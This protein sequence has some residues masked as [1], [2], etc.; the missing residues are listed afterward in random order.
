[1]ATEP[2]GL[3]ALEKV[4]AILAN[5]AIYE[6]ANLIPPPDPK[7]G[8]RPRDYPAWTLIFWEALISV[9]GSARRVE[10]ELS[11][12]LVWQ[13]IR[14]TVKR[15]FPDRPELHLPARPM[16]RHHYLYGRDRYLTDPNVLDALASRHRQLATAQARQF[17]LLDPEGPGSWTHPDLSRMLYADGKV[18]APLFRAK[19]GDTHVNRTT[20]EITLRRAEPDAGL[21]WEG[22]GEAAW[23]T[24]FVLVAART[25]D[26][27][28][29]II[30]DVDWVH[31]PGAEA[32]TAMGCFE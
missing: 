2:D 6:L 13:L 8:G 20:G 14:R 7:K 19:P 10:A 28:G 29:R 21:H 17:G 18:I 25:T 12:R 4:E 3:S 11:H 23:G 32:A 26:I 24:K 22:T 9:Y 1:M 16:R 15:R 27:R 31:H 5:P 30:V